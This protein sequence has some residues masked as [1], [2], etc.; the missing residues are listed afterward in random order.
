MKTIQEWLQELP[1]PYR[2]KALKNA[3]PCNIRLERPSLALAIRA[4]F[5]WEDSPEGAEYWFEA[6]MMAQAG[7]FDKLNTE[8]TPLLTGLTEAKPEDE[9]RAVSDTLHA[10]FGLPKM[11]KEDPV[12]IILQNSRRLKKGMLDAYFKPRELYIN[13]SDD[14]DYSEVKIDR[15]AD[16]E[17]KME[18]LYPE[19]RGTYYRISYGGMI[20]GWAICEDTNTPNPIISFDVNHIKPSAETCLN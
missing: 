9:I 3:N 19:S 12:M 1:E 15:D 5:I 4:A 8:F 11:P 10:V 6:Q 20:L 17:S 7:V 13:L 14:Y 18:K 2:S 16:Y